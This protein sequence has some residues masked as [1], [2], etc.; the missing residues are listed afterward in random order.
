MSRH[1]LTG[2]HLCLDKQNTII[3]RHGYFKRTG[4][5]GGGIGLRIGRIV[6]ELRAAA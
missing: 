5:A 2:P 1:M 6:R 4:S 3:R